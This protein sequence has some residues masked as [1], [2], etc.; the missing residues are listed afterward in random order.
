MFAK[1]NKASYHAGIVKETV[2]SDITCHVHTDA[3]KQ[4]H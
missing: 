1:L 4:G 3:P 2:S